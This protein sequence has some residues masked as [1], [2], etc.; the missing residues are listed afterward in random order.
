MFRLRPVQA[1]WF[2][3]FVPHEDTVRA[4]EILARTGVVELETDPRASDPLDTH[5]LRYF[6]QRG[7]DLIASHQEDLSAARDRPTALQGNPV[8]LANQAVHRLRLWSARLDF[9]KEHLA[10]KQAERDD[11]RLLDEALRAMRRDH[12][13]LDGLFSETRFLCKCLFAC[14]KTCRLE[15]S[16]V[17]D[18]P[19]LI[20]R[21]PRHDFPFMLGLADQRAIISHL[22][23][24]KGCEQVG[25]PAW[26][27]GDPEQRIHLVHQ[28]RVEL[29]HEI[30]RLEKA[31]SELRADPQIGCARA[32][33]DTLAWYLDNASRYLGGLEL[34]HVTGWTTAE[35]PDTLQQALWESGIEAV[36]RYPDPPEAAAPPV[37]TLQSW[38][39]QPFRPLLM[40]WGAPARREVDPSGLL[41][42]FVPLLFGYMFPDLGHGFL[43]VLF[44]LLFSRRWPETRFLLPCG[45]ASMAFGLLFG[46][47][48]GF[49]DL[50]PAL[51]LKPLEHPIIVMAVPLGFGMGLLLLGLILAG[52]EAKWNGALGAWLAV[53]AAVLEL[54]VALL[55]SLIDP[56][57]LYV[58][59]FAL[60]HYILGSLWN[61]RGEG[62]WALPN[63]LG[64]LLFSLFELMLNTLSFARVGAFA[65]A[66]AAFS[67]TIITLAQSVE[68]PVV[69]V[70]IIVL[71]NLLAI[72]LEGLVVFVQTT[73]LILFEFFIHFL[74][75]EGRLFRPVPRQPERVCRSAP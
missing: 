52:F 26:L 35:D 36:V 43:L 59:G 74:S 62:L 14:P 66:H 50:I 38:W 63:A 37:S 5:R 65:L 29:E 55:V 27:T 32:N 6:V 15:G 10:E 21:G 28:H 40:L 48:F 8:H 67:M 41:A 2:E 49:E 12:V 23:V 19:A 25:I 57:A 69:W 39:A 18:Q 3:T 68:S 1:R 60:A 46:E 30:F 44:A 54:Y 11:L 7:R 73:R 70:L 4:I 56:R 34:C 24:E 53:E 61:A 75:V 17:G 13:D 9:L 31:V 58:A 72:V 16:E 22:V 45:I 64:R 42:L 47:L 20:V 71:G 33:I 51:W